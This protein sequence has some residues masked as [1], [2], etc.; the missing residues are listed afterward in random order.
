VH[1]RANHAQQRSFVWENSTS[2]ERRE[3]SLPEVE[4]FLHPD[5]KTCLSTVCP[6]VPA[7]SPLL[8][9]VLGSKVRLDTSIRAVQYLEGSLGGDHGQVNCS[10]N[11]KP[12][13]LPQAPGTG[14]GFLTY[15]R[16]CFR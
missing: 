1:R 16:D 15:S 3:F 12:Q 8:Q 11:D 10:I 4:R 7:L 9:V 2:D 6:A 14:Q 13:A 5:S